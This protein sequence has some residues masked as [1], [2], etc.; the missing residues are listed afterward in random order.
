MTLK[1]IADELVA[2]CREN[3]TKDILDKLYAPDAESIEAMP[4]PGMDSVVTKGVEGIKGKHDWWG[5]N[6]TVHGASVDGPYPHGDDRFG[7]I[8][9]MDTTHNE[10]GQRSQ[11]KEIA[12]YTVA[13]GKIVKEEFF[14]NM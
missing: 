8:F 12:V 14:Y 1:E 9:E 3:R 4:G 6:F 5:A 10:S 13:S 7:V 11:M 2:G